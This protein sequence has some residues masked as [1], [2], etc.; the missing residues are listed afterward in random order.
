MAP[1]ALLSDKNLIMVSIYISL[2]YRLSQGA[3]GTSLIF[4][5]ALP[6][7]PPSYHTNLSSFSI[8][9]L[10]HYLSEIIS[11]GFIFSHTV[12]STK[13]IH[14]PNNFQERELAWVSRPG[15]WGLGGPLGLFDTLSF[16]IC[17]NRRQLLLTH[18]CCTWKRYI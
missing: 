11:V 2:I 10:F 6:P 4:S 18:S 3:K 17:K 13:A 9:I 15:P 14:V 8:L 1:W 16:L 7:I 5:I 12:V